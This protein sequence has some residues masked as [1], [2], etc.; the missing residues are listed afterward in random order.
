MGQS[1]SCLC[2]SVVSSVLFRCS[3]DQVC[4]SQDYIPESGEEEVREVD[5]ELSVSEDDKALE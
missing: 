4:K 2:G 5:S 3:K 1:S